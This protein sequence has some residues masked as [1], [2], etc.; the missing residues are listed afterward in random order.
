MENFAP[1]LVIT[2][3]SNQPRHDQWSHIAH[4]SGIRASTDIKPGLILASLAVQLNQQ[5][6]IAESPYI[7]WGDNSWL[8][9][10]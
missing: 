5:L 2:I 7:S 10:D 4:I 9:V 1:L 3:V 6:V 8:D